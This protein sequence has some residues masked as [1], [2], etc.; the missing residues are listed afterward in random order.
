MNSEDQMRFDPIKTSIAAA[1]LGAAVLGT[2]TVAF[3]GVDPKAGVIPPANDEMRPMDDIGADIPYGELSVFDQ[4]SEIGEDQSVDVPYCDHRAVLAG[5]LDADYQEAK[6][7]SMPLARDRSVE[8]WA[9]A[10]MGT[11]T[12][13]YTR[14]DGVSCVI[15]SG[16][17]WKAGNDPIALLT[18]EKV[19]PAA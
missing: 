19:L 10:E 2:V 7:L 9:S 3:S 12:A 17:G 15:S 4:I 13:V 1:A 8:L 14:S 6:Q 16:I 5:V 18:R 11:W